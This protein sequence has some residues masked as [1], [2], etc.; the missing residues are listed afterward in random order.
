MN[1]YQTQTLRGGSRLVPILGFGAAVL[2]T[3]AIVAGLVLGGGSGRNG[4]GPLPSSPVATPAPSE[5]P[6]EQP[7]DDPS[8]EPSAAPSDDPSAEPTEE[9]SDEPTPAPTD[10]GSDGMPIKVDLENATGHDVYVDIVD[11]SGRLEDA[12]S[13][14][15]GD[16]MSVE[17]YT[18]DVRNVDERTLRLTW[19][20]YGFDNA[21]AL[22][23]DEV[24][25][26]L[27]F[28]LVQPEPD[29]PVDAM[30]FDRE[31][32]LTFADPISAADVEAFLQDGLDVPG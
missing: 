19:V 21:L 3:L 29:G 1:G 17:P 14:T 8:A 26:G 13:G 27:R 15:P 10:G 5:S 30:G 6:S 20:D 28:V 18:L 23:I 9:P 11:R 25:G 7:S 22:F 16:G 4:G 2:M 24:D 12:V 31:L 32:V